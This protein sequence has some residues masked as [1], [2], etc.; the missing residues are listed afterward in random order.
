MYDCTW[1]MEG[2][3]GVRSDAKCTPEVGSLVT[4][5]DNTVKV[6]SY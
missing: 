6:Q 1:A 4:L 2:V 3:K 5:V